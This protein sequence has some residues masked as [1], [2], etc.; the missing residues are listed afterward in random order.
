VSL[1]LAPIGL[2]LK[3]LTQLRCFEDLVHILLHESIATPSKRDAFLQRLFSLRFLPV[4][5]SAMLELLP[6]STHPVDV[7][8]IGISL[9]GALEPESE[10]ND[11]ITIAYRLQSVAPLIL[12]HWHIWHEGGHR[13]QLGKEQLRPI[14]HNPN[15]TAAEFFLGTFHSSL[16]TKRGAAGLG[17]HLPDENDENEVEEAEA[18]T[19][20]TW[21][22]E[23]G[24]ALPE[25]MLSTDTQPEIS[26]FEALKLLWI[27]VAEDELSSSTF[28]GRV[29]ASAL[30]DFYGCIAASLAAYRGPLDSGGAA[31]VAYWQLCE[32][33]REG[34]KA[35]DD[36]P[37]VYKL[38]PV[39][40]RNYMQTVIASGRM[41][42]G[43][44]HRV[45]KGIDPRA[46]LLRQECRKMARLGREPQLFACALEMERIMLEDVKLHA[47]VEFF[48]GL[49]LSQLSLPVSL[50]SAICALARLPAWSAHILE[51]RANPCLLRP[52]AE[53]V[54]P[55][56]GL[57]T[58]E[59]KTT[60]RRR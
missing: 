46:S 13:L 51:Q 49:L 17:P 1:I 26:D 55:P 28:A 23:T 8:R 4:T 7:L 50:L 37:N 31:E 27:L 54:V 2:P 9:L 45:I 33:W 47:T 24:V 39:A 20:Q 42:M 59:S 19:Q 53:F 5:V 14:T 6:A 15:E 41:F 29:A 21:A 3:E 32:A 57:L 58:M 22:E 56:Q 43:F 44:G 34:R 48:A 35:G 25:V 12:L 30:S 52:I 36:A 11:A 40:L 10:I 38:D 18:F 16:H 60:A